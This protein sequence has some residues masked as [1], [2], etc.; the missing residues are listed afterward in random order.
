MTSRARIPAACLI[1]S[2]TTLAPHAGA[3]VNGDFSDP[4]DLAGWTSTG[5][6]IAAPTG[7]F[8]QRETDSSFQRMLEHSLALPSAPLILG[9]D[10]AVSTK[11]LAPGP[12]YLDSFAVSM[13]VSGGE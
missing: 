11:A 13:I 5:T 10:F 9:V 12:G 6:R 4:V 7:G 3:I 1:A 2:L 8:A